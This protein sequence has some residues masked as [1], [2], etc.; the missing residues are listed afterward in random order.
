MA[1]KAIAFRP[2]ARPDH[3]NAAPRPL[4]CRWQRDPDGQL[5]CRWMRDE[6][7][8]TTADRVVP[9]KRRKKVRHVGV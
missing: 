3:D 2:A 8:P 6:P 1:I 7:L 5:V 9:F 4:V